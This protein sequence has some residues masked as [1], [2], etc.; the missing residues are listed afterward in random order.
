MA[1]MAS[2]QNVLVGPDV[3]FGDVEL[4]FNRPLS[5]G[6]QSWEDDTLSLLPVRI[7]PNP[8]HSLPTSKAWGRPDHDE[9]SPFT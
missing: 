2:S 9:Q 6:I 8:R 3:V 1:M 4:L 5:E 7:S